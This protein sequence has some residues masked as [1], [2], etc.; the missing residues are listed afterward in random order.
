[1][2]ITS[3]TIMKTF[4]FS[5]DIIAIPLNYIIFVYLTELVHGMN[6]VLNDFIT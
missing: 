5:L 6:L 1:M 4:H 3:Y 2:I